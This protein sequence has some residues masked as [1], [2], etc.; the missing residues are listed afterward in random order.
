MTTMKMHLHIK[1]LT[2]ILMVLFTL[3][4]G[5]TSV[6]KQTALRKAHSFSTLLYR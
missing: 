3:M 5:C 1:N 6:V 2:F 4:C